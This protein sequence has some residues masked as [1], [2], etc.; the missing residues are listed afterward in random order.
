MY[1]FNEQ[2]KFESYDSAIEHS[3]KLEANLPYDG[4]RKSAKN[5]IFGIFTTFA[6]ISGVTLLVYIMKG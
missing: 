1:N 4:H 2:G 6:L 5:I 3:Q